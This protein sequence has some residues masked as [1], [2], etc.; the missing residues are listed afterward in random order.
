MRIQKRDLWLL[1]VTLCVAGATAMAA[2]R[3]RNVVSSKQDP[4]DDASQ[5]PIADASAPRPTDPQEIAKRKA[6][7]KK[8]SR[9]H[10]DLGPGMKVV[11][12]Y[13]LPP[14]FPELP[15]KES[16]A[17]VIGV[18]SK[19]AAYLT[20][21]ETGVYS[22]FTI[23]LDEI[24]KTDGRA[25]LSTG[26]SLIVDR[27]GGRVRY[28]TGQMGQFS[29]TGWGMPREGR[30]YVLFL[31]RGGEDEDY[32]I[33]TGYELRQGRVFPLDKSTHD[34]SFD[35]Y[36]NTEETSFLNKL[37]DAIAKSL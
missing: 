11:F 10:N 20:E 25:S 28:S 13:H 1:L 33:I 9:T 16:D 26:G 29:I 7:S 21:D 27:E 17:V 5:F 35:I 23:R 15:V 3:S 19:A 30:R 22:E 2:L 14:G 34:T 4:Q 37:R 6:K 12:H 18:V 8:Y 31:K 32:Q 36:A 24:L